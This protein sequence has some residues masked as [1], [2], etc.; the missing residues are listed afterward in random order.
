MRFNENVQL[1]T[2]Q[3][4]DRRGRGMGGGGLIAAG[5]GGLSLVGLLVALLLGVNPLGG[6]AGSV[7][8]GGTTSLSPYGGSP[9]QVEV[10]GSQVEQACRTGADANTRQDCRI[11]AV[12]NSIQAYWARELP[13]RGTRYVPART[14]FFSGATQAGCGYASSATGPFYCPRDQQIYLDLS[15]FQELQSRF[16][17]RGGPFAEAYVLAHEY[18]HH[19]QDIL[20]LLDTQGSREEGPQGQAVRTELQADC[21]AGVWARN[22]TDTGY[23]VELTQADIAAGLDAA[24]AVGDDRIQRST[25]GRVTPESWTHG[26]AQQRQTWFTRGLSSGDLATCDTSRGRV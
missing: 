2:S 22:A 7:P 15:F 18:G 23:I 9:G 12:V 1:D 10:A 14:T 5:G 11:V 4:D 24:A 16:G 17:A 20:G 26:S 6:D 19:V 13:R 3:V 25:Q 21:F 8:G